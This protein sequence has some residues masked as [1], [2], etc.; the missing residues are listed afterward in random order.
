[1]NV[2]LAVV[3][4]VAA[5]GAIDNAAPI[6]DPPGYYGKVDLACGS[7]APSIGTIDLS[8]MG[9]VWRPFSCMQDGRSVSVKLAAIDL[10]TEHGRLMFE[11]LMT[12]A[13]NDFN[14]NIFGCDNCCLLD[15]QAAQVEYVDLLNPP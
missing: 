8:D 9:P 11:I 7:Y 13:E 3:L 4:A 15:G 10:R 12:A 5:D 2:F 14:V 6:L 1:M